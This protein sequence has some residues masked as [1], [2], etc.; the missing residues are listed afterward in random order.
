MFRPGP[1]P[2]AKIRG[3]SYDGHRYRMGEV[4]DADSKAQ[5]AT[6]RPK[7]GLGEITV[8]YSR[9]AHVE[10]AHGFTEFAVRSYGPPR[11]H[12]LE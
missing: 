1:L 2:A 8:P 4:I 9:I 7:N 10:Q 12:I 3:V 5:Q 11:N 6:I